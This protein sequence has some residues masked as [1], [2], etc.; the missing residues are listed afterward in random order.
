MYYPGYSGYPGG[1]VYP[2]YGNNEGGYG[3][4]W[5]WIIVIVF[6]IFFL[7]WG[8][9]SNRGNSCGCNKY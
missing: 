4:G 2:V 1:Y 8:F 9:G 6:I 7:F 3:T 5:I